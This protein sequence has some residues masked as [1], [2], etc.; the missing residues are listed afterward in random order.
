MS[1]VPPPHPGR[2]RVVSA[3]HELVSSDT[4]IDLGRIIKRAVLVKCEGMNLGGSAK[5]RSAAAMVAAAERDGLIEDDTILVESTSGNLGVA[6]SVIAAS[7]GLR[8]TCVTD[9]RCNA[10]AA[11][12]IRA[13]GAELLVVDRPHPVGGYLQARLDLI[14]GLCARNSHYLWLNQY[15]NQANC[16]AHYEGT[17]PEI[18]A[19]F[20]DLDVLFVGVGTG[21]TSVGCARYVRDRQLPARVVAVDAVGSVT[22]GEAPGRRLIPGLGASVTPPMFDRTLFAGFVSVPELDTVRTCRMLASYGM[23]F[24]GSTG[25]VLCGAMAWLE[26]HDPD[27]RLRSVCISAD[28]GDRYLHTIYNDGWVIE[29]FGAVALAS[30]SPRV[31]AGAGVWPSAS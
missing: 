15:V 28:L 1:G 4:Y 20:P 29:H 27:R 31:A 9:P 11:A 23:L 25:T 2:A 14:R 17:A 18:F 6:L 22:F 7:K 5:M 19:A 10:A 16:D 24:G 21:G 8:F 12:A 13:L 26:R 3:P 30:T